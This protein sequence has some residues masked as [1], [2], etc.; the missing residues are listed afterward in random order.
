M[1]ALQVDEN[2]HIPTLI[3]NPKVVT[4]FIWYTFL[5]PEFSK[6]WII[7]SNGLRK[8][9]IFFKWLSHKYKSSSW[10]LKKNFVLSPKI[11]GCASIERWPFIIYA[12]FLLIFSDSPTSGPFHT[13]IC[14][15]SVWA[16]IQRHVLLITPY[17]SFPRDWYAYDS[18]GAQDS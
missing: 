16:V 18:L 1:C 2:C 10:G 9:I 14:R 6:V 4:R 15:C 7:Y 17:S 5:P 11:T 8:K 12:F 3:A 13:T